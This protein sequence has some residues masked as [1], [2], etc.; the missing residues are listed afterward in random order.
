MSDPMYDKIE[1]MLYGDSARPGRPV[2]EPT[3]EDIELRLA[4]ARRVR[5]VVQDEL[6]VELT[7]DEAADLDTL[8]DAVKLLAS[9]GASG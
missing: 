5:E 2:A 1:S 4:G 7:D 6:G 3:F 9:K 8:D